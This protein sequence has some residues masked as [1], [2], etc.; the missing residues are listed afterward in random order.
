VK[1]GRLHDGLC[2]YR[3]LLIVTTLL[4][5]AP[6]ASGTVTEYEDAKILGFESDESDRFGGSVSL[7]GGVALVGAPGDEVGGVDSGWA[8][9]YRHDGNGW[10]HEQKLTASDAQAGDA[11]GIAV[12][13]FGNVAF[14]GAR[15]DDVT[16]IYSGSAYVFEFDGSTW[17]ELERISPVDS[18]A[19]ARFGESIAVE[20][21]LAIIGAPYSVNGG[22]TTGSAYI[23]RYNGSSWVEETELLASDGANADRFGTSVSISG[24]LA[25]VGARFSD[26][27]GNSGSG[28]A[29]VFRYNGSAW[30][31]EAKLVPADPY[32]TVYFGSAVSISGDRAL[33]G[34]P[35]GH[36]SVVSSGVAYVFKFNEVDWVQEQKLEASDPLFIDNYGVSVALNGARA[37]VGANNQGCCGSTY[38]IGAAYD[39]RLHNGTWFEVAKFIP[40]DTTSHIQLGGSVAVSG[41]AVLVGAERDDQNG[42][43]AG[44]AY[45]YGQPEPVSVPSV[46]LFGVA[47][48]VAVLAAAGSRSIHMNDRHSS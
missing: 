1:E 15:R 41:K 44:S 7:S 28:S 23:F 18:A 5:A 22:I 25:L 36:G 27:G 34:A 29:Y 16:G 33:V 32:P 19:G 4:L 10:N 20:G 8:Y 9:V 45:V 35:L 17:N 24:D 43:L 12:S 11:F 31:E 13:V 26:F 14:I 2:T 3:A 38:D 6:A 39:I 46:S 30:V 42:L 40:S 48:L 37:I 47:C 21:S